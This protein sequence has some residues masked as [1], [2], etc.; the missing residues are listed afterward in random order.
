MK[1]ITTGNWMAVAVMALQAGL[2]LW[3][4]LPGQLSTD[5]IVQMYEGQSHQ[6]ISFNP[7][8]MA[9]ILGVLDKL[10]SAPIG[11]VLLSQALFT[12]ALWLA[13]GGRVMQGRWWKFLFAIA[14]VSNPV[15]L[16]YTGIVWKDVLFAHATTFVFLWIAHWHE[17]ETKPG[18]VQIGLAILL[19][20]IVVGVRQQGLLFVVIASW[21][22]ATLHAKDRLRAFALMVPLVLA[23]L[24]I[25]KIVT[26]TV[27]RPLDDPLAGSVVGFKILMQYDLVGIVVN[28]GT[29]PTRDP[30]SPE[31][32]ALVE[33]SN[34]VP[35]YSAYRVDS[36]INPSPTFWS[37]SLANTAALW[38]EGIEHSPNA[39]LRHRWHQAQTFLGL[40]DVRQCAPVFS[41]TGGPVNHPL[42]K[43][44]LT[45]LLGLQPGMNHSSQYVIETAWEL[46]K[47]PLL[48]H[49]AYLLVLLVIA[50]VLLFQR[51]YVLLS[52]VGCCFIYFGSYFVLGIACDFRYGYVLTVSAS[53]LAVA[54]LFVRPKGVAAAS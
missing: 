25:N 29:L 49:W 15:I 37:L 20:T 45:S 31:G 9:I 52:L 8:L 13:F 47:T 34:Q 53:L 46:A 39:Y 43:Q 16:A 32:K 35:L 4:G 5:S 10:G 40:E 28:G 7:A 2:A 42:V 33:L 41:G 23:P 24:L 44:E 18:V 19:M 14:L 54:A 12:G 26:E 3:A 1:A 22:L 50:S 6:T 51:R 17:C 11:F 21:W 38:R 36:L 27:Q 48:M 30:V